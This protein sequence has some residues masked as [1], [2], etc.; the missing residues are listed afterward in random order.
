MNDQPSYN[1]QKFQSRRKFLRWL[2]DLIAFR[3][4]MRLDQ[5][6]GTENIPVTGPAILIYNHIASGDPG[7]IIGNLP[8]HPVPLAKRETYKIP[9]WGMFSRIWDIIP[10]NR[11][12]SDRE[13]LLRSLEVLSA[14]E[15]IL[16][17]PEGTR[18]PQLGY[19][20]DGVA[21]LAWKSGAPIVPIAVSGTVGFPTFS[22][23]RWQQPGAHL[24]FGKPFRL[25]PM[26][27]R[28]RKEQLE[29]ISTEIMV[30]IA[31]LLPPE[32]RGVYAAH[33]GQPSQYL[34]SLE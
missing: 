25:A 11:T 21:Y 16:I 12:G 18:N 30:K 4:L 34:Q 32:L 24:V 28:P 31:E 22:R 1:H 33:V 23:K 6:S 9:I 2:I 5:V 10:V 8:R 14:G 29:Q 19:A 13:A 20:Q 7:L 27:Q 17:A 26:S 15:T 3:F